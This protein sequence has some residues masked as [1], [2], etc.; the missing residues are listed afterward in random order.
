MIVSTHGNG[1]TDGW[2]L[3]LN[4][5]GTAACYTTSTGGFTAPNYT[6]TSSNIIN[7]AA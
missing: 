4:S 6:A 2:A 5:N 1:T 7:Y 3:Y